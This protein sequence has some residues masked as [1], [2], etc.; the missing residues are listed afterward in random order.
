MANRL[1]FDK[2]FK[3]ISNRKFLKMEGLG[4]EVPF[5]VYTYDISKQSDIYE[6]IN[7]L[8]KKLETKGI[9][10]LLTGLYDMVIDYF[11]TTGELKDLFEYEESVSKN[12]F[13]KELAGTINAEDVIKP[14]FFEK[15]EE[16]QYK[17]ILVYQIG[18]V[19]PFL[20]TH[21]VLNYIQSTIKNI[22]LIVFFPGK[23]ITSYE[24]GF[25]LN[26]FGIFNGPY[27]RAFRLE[28]YI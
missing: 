18:E 7:T 6:K 12:D 25:Y 16:N 13:L 22:P 15:L 5:F 27:Y 11:N 24:Q 20:R 4:K 19:F 26:L 17:V 8:C 28:A 23:Y 2:L 21:N 3:V 10:V 9:P 1:S 14:Y